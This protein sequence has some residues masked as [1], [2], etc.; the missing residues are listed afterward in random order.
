MRSLWLKTILLYVFPLCAF[1]SPIQV[2]TTCPYTTIRDALE[3]AT[4][5]DVIEVADPI[6]TESGIIIKKDITLQGAP[7]TI[8]QAAASTTESNDRVIF[9]QE[10]SLTLRGLTIRHGKQENGGA[11]YA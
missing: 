6:H 1:A 10:G 11:L 4:P 3:A 5:G 8:I 9:V 7:G 2:C